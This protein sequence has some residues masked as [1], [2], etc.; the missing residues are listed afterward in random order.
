MTAEPIRPELLAYLRQQH[1]EALLASW[2]VTP[3]A[4]R[5]PVLAA[6]LAP[7]LQPRGEVA[8]YSQPA[9]A[10]A[11][12]VYAQAA[13]ARSIGFKRLGTGVLVACCGLGLWFAGK[14][15][16]EIGD[17][18][19][20]AGIGLWAVAAMVIASACSKLFAPRRGGVSVRVSG[21]H[22]NVRL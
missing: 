15:V 20:D 14:G 7:A 22:N 13:L 10:A 3:S 1:D 17:G 11:D 2:P 16:H 4:D 19:R 6:Q 18:I 5:L 8:L 9:P 12:L 21:H